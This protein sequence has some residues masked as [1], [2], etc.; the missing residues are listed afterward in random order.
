MHDHIEEIL[1]TREEIDKRVKELGKQITKD[2]KGKNLTCI[3]LLKGG[4]FFMTD[5][6]KEIDLPLSIDFMDVSSYGASTVSSGEVR[7]LKDLDHSIKD[8]DILLVEDIIDTG[9]TLSHVIELLKTR[10]INSIEVVS[11]LS[12]EMRREVDIDI[13]YCG[14]NIDD[15]FVVGYGLDFDEE[16]RNL[17]YIGYL[18]EE[19][20]KK[21]D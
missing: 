6:L 17:P 18:K 5:L 14:F 9:L 4:V 1:Y 8:K 10:E 13:K 11:F 7:I 21:E 20:Y 19:M 15:Y 12:K 16:Y 3:C 2:Y